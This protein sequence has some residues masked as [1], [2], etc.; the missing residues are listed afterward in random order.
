M[1]C[2]SG[3]CDTADFFRLAQARRSEEEK[4]SSQEGEPVPFERD[5]GSTHVQAKEGTVTVA[6]DQPHGRVL[7]TIFSAR[8]LCCCIA[9]QKRLACIAHIK[10]SVLREPNAQVAGTVILRIDNM[11]VPATA[12][13]KT[14][15]LVD[16]D[17]ADIHGSP[18]TE[19]PLAVGRGTVAVAAANERSGRLLGEHTFVPP[20]CPTVVNVSA[21][22]TGGG[23]QLVYK[24]PSSVATAAPSTEVA[25]INKRSGGTNEAAQD[26]VIG[27]LGTSPPVILAGGDIFSPTPASAVN[28]LTGS[29]PTAGLQHAS[30]L[31]NAVLPPH[32]SGA[33]SAMTSEK[34]VAATSLHRSTSP[35]GQQESTNGQLDMVIAGASLSSLPAVPAAAAAVS[36]HYSGR[37][38]QRAEIERDN[39]Q[40][41]NAARSKEQARLS[42]SSAGVWGNTVLTGPAPTAGNVTATQIVKGGVIKTTADISPAD[43]INLQGALFR[44]ADAVS[45]RNGR[46]LEGVSG[47]VVHHHDDDRGVSRL[48][49]VYQLSQPPDQVQQQ[50]QAPAS[51]LVGQASHQEQQTTA[52]PPGTVVAAIAASQLDK[53]THFD[54][55]DDS[56]ASFNHETIFFMSKRKL[57]DLAAE[58]YRLHERTREGMVRAQIVLND[59]LVELTPWN[60]ERLSRLQTQG[61]GMIFMRLPCSVFTSEW[62]SGG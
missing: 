11:P 1:I 60:R 20:V 10:F 16:S 46:I 31:V 48:P 4:S 29:V 45:E 47:D 33:T 5:D 2:L 49:S 35:S 61:A 18:A 23:E 21:L 32:L 55:A 14:P 7:S 62:C 27:M 54:I 50:I 57:D 37:A 22:G 26:V 42:P 13:P 34:A 24:A 41:A 15:A 30:T 52:K 17:E 19:Q 53:R 3:F 59:T 36:P 38:A 12:V 39:P 58:T 56:Q 25:R 40:K 28:S 6:P 9:F 8:P 43:S 51:D 44:R